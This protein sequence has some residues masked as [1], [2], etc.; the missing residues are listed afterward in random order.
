[1][2]EN[3]KVREGPSIDALWEQTSGCSIQ[4]VSTESVAN[5]TCFGIWCAIH[6]KAGVLLENLTFIHVIIKTLEYEVA[7]ANLD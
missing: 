3:K 6:K 5:L 4:S 1:M 7:F 2:V